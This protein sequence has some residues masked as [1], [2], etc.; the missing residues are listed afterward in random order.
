MKTKHL[1]VILIVLAVSLL[2]YAPSLFRS[3]NR[4]QPA[5]GPAFRIPLDGNP[6]LIRVR[7]GA[8][9]DTVRLERIDGR[10]WVNGHHADTSRVAAA[11][12][13]LA[14]ATAT[15]IVARNPANHARMGVTV[16]SGRVVEIVTDSGDRVT[17]FLGERDLA[18]GGYY[19]RAIDGTEVF[20]TGGGGFGAQLYRPLGRWR[21]MTIV[22]VP[23]EQANAL[24]LRRGDEEIHLVRRAGG[25][26]VGDLA[27]DSA[28]VEIVLQMLSDLMSTGFPPD[29]LVAATDLDSPD[30]ILEVFG[31]AAEDVTEVEPAVSLLFYAGSE[32][33]TEWL[34][35]RTR[36]GEM[37]ELADYRIGQLLPDLAT[38]LGTP[39]NP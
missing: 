30:A 29:S 23:P 21:D 34:V 36:D 20:R 8:T 33:R 15:E 13:D 22:R 3:S 16:E 12:A 9:G 25:W 26:T 2:L 27:A 10:W 35:A 11:L 18:A 4:G 31:S 24:R 37:F 38:L 6:T 28:V 1:V 5:D 39:P 17:F 7:N 14:S 19:V 32:G